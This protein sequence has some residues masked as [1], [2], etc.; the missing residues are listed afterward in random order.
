MLPQRKRHIL[1][2]RKDFPRPIHPVSSSK[3]TQKHWEC[4][5]VCKT[6]PL[7]THQ[8][9]I[10]QHSCEGANTRYLLGHKDSSGI[11]GLVTDNQVGLEERIKDRHRYTHHI[12]LWDP[13]TS[14]SHMQQLPEKPGHEVSRQ[15]P[16]S[17]AA[18]T[19]PRLL[20]SKSQMLCSPPG[21]CLV[22]HGM[23]PD[24]LKYTCKNRKMKRVCVTH[25]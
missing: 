4:R 6:N 2:S 17:K 7:R 19:T 12:N 9:H 24:P 10:N 14:Q 18:Q 25:L 22:A 20:A 3:V 13:L 11:S 15:R 5:R 16:N 8:S 21:R 23:W 1:G